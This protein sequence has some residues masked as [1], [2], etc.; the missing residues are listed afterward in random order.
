MKRIGNCIQMLL[1]HGLLL[2]AG[3]GLSTAADV[4]GDDAWG[5]MEAAEAVAHVNEGD[6][7]FLDQPPSGPVHAHY[8][9]I[10]I[11]T[12][13]LNDGWAALYQCHTH[14]DVVPAAQ[15]VF[16]AERI[17]SL[18]VKE[19]AGIGQARVEGA[20]VQLED[21]QPGARLCLAA[22]SRVIETHADGGFVVRNGPFMRRFLD[23]FY[24]MHV[25][26][27]FIL[28]PGAW[29]LVH[30]QPAA[31]S[32][33]TVTEEAGRVRVDTWFEGELRTEFYF[34]PRAVPQ[35]D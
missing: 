7:R 17:R 13:S 25:T 8:N 22:E 34:R 27:E 26:L 12:R 35:E 1:L 6:L 14:L 28:P 30:S 9:R 2:S 29:E 24:P 32:G 4:A 20:S 16:N 31:Q 19:V 21:V 18:Q 3:T 15:V 5:D 23:G 11:T 10:G 33:F